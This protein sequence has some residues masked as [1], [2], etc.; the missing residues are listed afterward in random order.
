[1]KRTLESDIN[2]LNINDLPNE[3]LNIIIQNNIHKCRRVCKKWHDILELNKYWEITISP[4]YFMISLEN[5]ND[6]NVYRIKLDLRD[7]KVVMIL[8]NNNNN[9]NNNEYILD[10][11]DLDLDSTILNNKN[12]KIGFQRKDHP[13]NARILYTYNVELMF[14]LRCN[15]ELLNKKSIRESLIVVYD[16]MHNFLLNN[17]NN[18]LHNRIF[19]TGLTPIYWM[20]LIENKINNNNFV[21]IYERSKVLGYN[22]YFDDQNIYHKN[23]VKGRYQYTGGIINYNWLKSTRKSMINYCVNNNPNRNITH[24]LSSKSTLIITTRDQ[25]STWSSFILDLYPESKIILIFDNNSHLSITYKDIIGADF[26][27]CTDLYLL[28]QYYDDKDENLSFDLDYDDRLEYDTFKKLV[29]TNFNNFTL[30]SLNKKGPILNY[31]EWT[32]FIV[33]RDIY[34]H[35]YLAEMFQEFN[36][37]YKWILTEH[38]N[39]DMFIKYIDLLMKHQHNDLFSSN[40]PN[41]KELNLSNYNLL[42]ILNKIYF[43]NN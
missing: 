36:T 17:T 25:F 28:S 11:I 7:S 43:Y 16:K 3:I 32:R 42:S 38:H 15:M 33:D 4:F 6:I 12:V 18:F 13:D 37:K 39:K 9:N 27:L 14:N 22:L 29:K 30:G 2:S 23:K 19:N 40:I 20:Y 1:M 10:N 8:Y 5:S 34:T 21:K 24:I 35:K 41:H 26:V 31:F